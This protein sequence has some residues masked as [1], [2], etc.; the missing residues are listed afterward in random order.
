[1]EIQE[2]T[3][4]D[5]AK[6]YRSYHEALK[7]MSLKQYGEMMFSINDYVFNGMLPVFKSKTM[8]SLWEII[9]WRIDTEKQEANTMEA[10]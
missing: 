7:T 3:R 8:Q 6:I 9:K 4:E 10:Q 2:S 1:M 5:V